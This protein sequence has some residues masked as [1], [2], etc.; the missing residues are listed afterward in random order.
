[1]DLK[2]NIYTFII[3]DYNIGF[4]RESIAKKFFELVKVYYNTMNSY[5]IIRQ[6]GCSQKKLDELN[7]KLD[8][9]YDILLSL[10]NQFFSISDKADNTNT[11][12][13]INEAE[14]L[15]NVINKEY[16]DE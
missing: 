10:S 6:S 15:R 7:N 8:R 3:N 5:S 11:N 1:M 16:M 9:M 14:A 2:T 4:I 13:L 12:D